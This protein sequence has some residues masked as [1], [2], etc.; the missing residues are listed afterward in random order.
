MPPGY[1]PPG[2]YGNV[3]F[4]KGFAIAEISP[5][6]T[7]SSA[8]GSSNSSRAAAYTSSDSENWDHVSQPTDTAHTDW[9]E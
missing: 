4:A 6:Y 3:F 9:Q 8:V 1:Y 7:T 2:Q 5:T